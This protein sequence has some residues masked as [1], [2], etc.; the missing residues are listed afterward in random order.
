[1]ALL[2][3]KNWKKYQHYTDRKPAW[4]K[5]HRELLDD[6]D[7]HLLPLASRALA[8]LFWLL[9]SEH[10][11]GAVPYD[12]R[13][14][15]FRLR[16]SEADVMAALT[17]LIESGFLE[18]IRETTEEKQ[19]VTATASE[20]LAGVK[21]AASP[22]RERETEEERERERARGAPAAGEFRTGSEIGE[23]LR[24]SGFA[25]IP[26]GADTQLQRLKPLTAEHL[27]ALIDDIDG[28]GKP[29][30]SC[31]LNYLRP[32]LEDLRAGRHTSQRQAPT[33]R[34]T[35]P[36]GGPAPA[37]EKSPERKRLEA[38]GLDHGVAAPTPAE[39]AAVLD[40]APPDEW[41]NKILAEPDASWAT[42]VAR[43][44]ELTAQVIP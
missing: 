15:A 1:M 6:L 41:L 8:P 18:V 34:S 7:F 32:I 11:G 30:E 26:L 10:D 39:A 31:S 28:R 43:L 40:G 23:A 22:E 27:R 9:A 42:I 44:P 25:R 29:R 4:I 35:A 14:I 19:P 17:P 37:P 2:R 21:Q 36:P 3:V 13:R 5:L 12:V 33:R 38:L 16:A 24:A 20:P